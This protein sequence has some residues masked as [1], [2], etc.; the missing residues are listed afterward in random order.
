MN[1][2][3][4]MVN[5]IFRSMDQNKLRVTK[6]LDKINTLWSKYKLVYGDTPITTARIEGLYDRLSLVKYHYDNLHIQLQE[7]NNSGDSFLEGLFRLRKVTWLTHGIERLNNELYNIDTS[8]SSLH[9]TLFR[10]TD[11]CNDNK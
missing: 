7:I 1:N 2:R 4:N 5:S 10:D 11:I 9:D 3:M 8:I 6:A